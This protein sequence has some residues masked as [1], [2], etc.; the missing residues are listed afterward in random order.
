MA[1]TSPATLTAPGAIFLVATYELGHQPLTLA[2]PLA[3]LREAGFAPTARDTS[4]EDLSEGDIRAARLVAISTPMH[5]ALRLGLQVAERVRQRNPDAVILFY[6]LYAALNAGM[7]LREARAD[8]VTGGEYQQPLL[9]LAQA[10]ASGAALA[11]LRVPGLQTRADL[12]SWPPLLLRGE[13]GMVGGHGWPPGSSGSARRP[14]SSS[15][16]TITAPQATSATSASGSA[17]GTPSPVSC[18]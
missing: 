17:A 9:A 6:G 8:A 18:T 14:V 7:L 16:T 3:M 5:T 13:G 1:G 15:A 4:V 11:S 12:T 2:A 10:L